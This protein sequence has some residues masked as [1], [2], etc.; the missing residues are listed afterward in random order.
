MLLSRDVCVVVRLQQHPGRTPLAI[1]A[2]WRVGVSIA[3][4]PPTGGKLLSFH[5]LLQ[6]SWA[7]SPPEGLQAPSQVFS[8][9]G[10]SLMLSRRHHATPSHLLETEAPLVL[11]HPLL[12]VAFPSPTLSSP[13]SQCVPSHTHGTPW[14]MR[15]HW[16][17]QLLH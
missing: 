5:P 8:S 9:C 1:L 6:L 10:G 2:L 14:L 15:R 12:L 4:L 3:Y 7:S 16:E 11:W 13:C 17:Q